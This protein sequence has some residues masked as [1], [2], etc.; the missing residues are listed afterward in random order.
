MPRHQEFKIRIGSIIL[1]ESYPTKVK[2]RVNTIL[3]GERIEG[4]C[5]EQ[6]TLAIHSVGQPVSGYMTDILQVISF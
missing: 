4:T 2:I 1:I 6:D 3:N 5:V